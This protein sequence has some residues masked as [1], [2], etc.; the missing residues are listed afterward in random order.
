MEQLCKNHKH[1]ETLTL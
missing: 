1:F